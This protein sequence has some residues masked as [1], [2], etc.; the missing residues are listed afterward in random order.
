MRPTLSL[1][2]YIYNP[3]TQTDQVATLHDLDKM[4]ET[5]E[6]LHDK[7]IVLAGNFKFFFDTFLDSY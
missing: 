5:I 1:S 7:H 3:N 2:I 6:D 4:L